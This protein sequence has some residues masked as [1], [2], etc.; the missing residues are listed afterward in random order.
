MRTMRF[1]ICGFNQET[2]RSI[3]TRLRSTGIFF[4]AV[5]FR[6]WLSMER[7]QC[8]DRIGGFDERLPI[9]QDHH[10][11]L[12]V[13]EGIAV[14]YLAEPLGKYRVIR[15]LLWPIRAIVRGLSPL[16]V[17]S[18]RCFS[19]QTV[20]PDDL[21]MAAKELYISD[22]ADWH[23]LERTSTNLT[24]R[25]RANRSA[26]RKHPELSIELHGGLSENLHARD[27][28]PRAKIRRQ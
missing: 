22:V 12:K 27:P 3:P 4:A 18:C 14:G 8:L 6:R 11:W 1:C 24:R 26:I 23:I 16:R 10:H 25:E 9:A 28:S 17:G 5:T 15:S 19:L 7:R 13:V 20:E 2:K 21:D